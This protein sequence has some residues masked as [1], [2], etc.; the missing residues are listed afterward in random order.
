MRNDIFQASLSR[1]FVY[2]SSSLKG[3]GRRFLRKNQSLWTGSGRL[4]RCISINVC[5]IGQGSEG[6]N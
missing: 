1:M 2:Q 4:N 3:K 6:E 5:N